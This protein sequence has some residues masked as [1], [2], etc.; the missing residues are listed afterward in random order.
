LGQPENAEA[1]WRELAESW[2]EE[3]GLNSSECAQ[4]LAS[5]GLNLL[6][7]GKQA[8]AEPTLRECL[9]IREKKLPDDWLLF[10]TKSMLG[11]A[12]VGQKKFQEAEPLVVEGYSGMKARA[13][14]IPPAAQ[15]R[16]ADAIRR[17]VDLYTAWGKP[18]KTAKWRKESE[19]L[20]SSNDEGNNPPETE[21]PMKCLPRILPDPVL[22]PPSRHEVADFARGEHFGRPR[23]GVAF[24]G[25][26]VP[27]R[28]DQCPF[29]GRR[30]GWGRRGRG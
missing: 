26:F 12:L 10:D 17:L 18:D 13:A 25:E 28:R 23:A 20:Q 27:A 24:G 21:G 3:A 9:T 16:L 11:G 14:Q 30:R 8:K 19:S 5:L 2:S 4:Q 6:Q 7:Q 15:P 1:L 22:C 29:C